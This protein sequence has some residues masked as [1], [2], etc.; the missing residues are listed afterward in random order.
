MQQAK[1]RREA[2]KL[3]YNAVR[4]V[5]IRGVDHRESISVGSVRRGRA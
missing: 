2:A 3:T 1:T 4:I 5:R